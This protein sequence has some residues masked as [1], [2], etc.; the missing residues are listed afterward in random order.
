VQ[1]IIPAPT[2]AR[3]IAGL[4]V[5]AAAASSLEAQPVAYAVDPAASHVRIHLNRSKLKFL[6]HDHEIEAP[7]AEGS[8]QV[9]DDDPPRSSVALRLSDAHGRCLAYLTFE[10]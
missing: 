6:G 5:F 9:A 2:V 1:A 4:V 10:S 7:L 8:V 3:L